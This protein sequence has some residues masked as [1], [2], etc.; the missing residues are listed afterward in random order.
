MLFCADRPENH[1][2]EVN[3][4][5]RKNVEIMAAHVGDKLPVP[6]VDRTELGRDHHRRLIVF[7]EHI[8][9]MI[10]C[11]DELRE[12]N[13]VTLRDGFTDPHRH[14]KIR[15]ITVDF[16]Q[17]IQLLFIFFSFPL[18]CLFEN[19]RYNFRF[20]RIHFLLPELLRCFLFD[21]K[22]AQKVCMPVKRFR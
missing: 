11:S 4:I 3:V 7:F 9:I 5:G 1:L 8:D 17:H 13:S 6:H 14:G 15:R 10:C 19:E 18:V 22:P 21:H 2:T 20:Y 16:D 12:D